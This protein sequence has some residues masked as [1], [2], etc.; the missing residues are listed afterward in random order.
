MS[1]PASVVLMSPA[2]RFTTLRGQLGDAFEVIELDSS[3]GN[4]EGYR[5]MAHSV[6][7]RDLREDPPNSALKARERTVEF[8]RQHLT[9]T[10]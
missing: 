10:E 1:K 6:L 5:T 3:P 2:D 7:T 8:L 9:A 4:R